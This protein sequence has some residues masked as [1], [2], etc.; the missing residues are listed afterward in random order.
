[1]F[2]GITLLALLGCGWTVIGGMD[3]FAARRNANIPRILF[4]QGLLTIVIGIVVMLIQKEHLDWQNPQFIFIAGSLVV[5]GIA[6]YLANFLLCLSMALGPNGIIWSIYQAAMLVPF[7]LGITIHHDML[8]AMRIIGLVLLLT[9]LMALG[10]GG[11]IRKMNK[12][13]ASLQNAPALTPRTPKRLVW[14]IPALLAFLTNGMTMYTLALPSR[15]QQN[16]LEL[17][18]ITRSTLLHLG[19][20][21]GSIVHAFFKKDIIAL[22]TKIEANLSIVFIIIGLINYYALQFPGIDLLTTAGAGAIALAIP[23]GVCVSAFTIYSALRLKE[24]YTPLEWTG[25]VA[26]AFG[27]V[28]ITL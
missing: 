14:L 23:V 13:F 3:S 12:E 28:V 18:S 4:Y 27:V 20:V 24:K 21:L 6:A 17:S 7:A 1:M 11:D 19:L 9:G 2:L 16:D 5:S 10:I 22:P 25:L 8:T 15:F 26:C